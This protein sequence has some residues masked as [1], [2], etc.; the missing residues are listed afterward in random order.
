MGKAEKVISDELYCISE[1][2]NTLKLSHM[3]KICE[4]RNSLFRIFLMHIS[5][6]KL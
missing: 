6:E 3:C 1:Q 2:T 4:S 5:V